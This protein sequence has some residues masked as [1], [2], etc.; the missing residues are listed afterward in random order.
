MRHSKCYSSR[1]LWFLSIVFFGCASPKSAHSAICCFRTQKTRER[2]CIFARRR[3]THSH[4][5]AYTSPDKDIEPDTLTHTCR[6]KS[7][8]FFAHVNQ[9]TTISICLVFIFLSYYFPESTGKSSPIS[10]LSHIAYSFIRRF[11]CPLFSFSFSSCSNGT[12]TR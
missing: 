8:C 9:Q 11:Y 5:H 12:H 10:R 7:E 2:T 1:T 6:G 4:T 3:V